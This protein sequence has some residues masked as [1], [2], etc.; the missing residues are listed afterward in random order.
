MLGIRS[1]EYRE[2]I[3]A[4]GS[5]AGLLLSFI[6]MT[7][8]GFVLHVNGMQRHDSMYVFLP[9]VMIFLYQLLSDIGVE[10]KKQ[11]RRLSTWIYILHPAIIVV[12]RATAKLVPAAAHVV[13]NSLLN[14]VAVS[15]VSV[16]TAWLVNVAVNKFCR[17]SAGCIAIE[18]EGYAKDRAWIE[19]DMEALKNNVTFLKN[20]LP[21]GCELMPAVKAQAYGHGAVPITKQDRKSTRLNSSHIL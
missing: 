18:C 19:L 9:A 13:G 1:E 4:R 7:V 5:I 12:V 3:S 11:L 21:A 15:A 6:L 17:K 2:K 14:F 8:E 10:P 16:F 20:M